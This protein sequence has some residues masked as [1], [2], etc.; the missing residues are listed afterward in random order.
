MDEE[1]KTSGSSVP[2]RHRFRFFLLT[3]LVGVALAISL[4][5][6]GR[7]ATIVRERK[8]MLAGIESAGG[9]YFSSKRTTAGFWQKFPV[10]PQAAIDSIGSKEAPG[11]IE[12]I[13]RCYLGDESVVV[14]W[15]P[16]AIPKAE[17][18]RIKQCIPEAYIWRFK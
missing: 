2:A 1:P 7:Q 8:A 10:W 9:G 4:S 11:A 5:Y 17:A 14:I 13:T 16:A 12:E 3:I 6:V 18:I 15:L